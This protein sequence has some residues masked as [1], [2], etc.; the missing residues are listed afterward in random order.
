[1]AASAIQ[2][3]V[4]VHKAISLKKGETLSQFTE[5]LSAAVRGKI[6]EALRIAK[7]KGSA[8][9]M[10][11]TEKAVIV[12]TYVYN[13]SGS[14]YRTYMYKY[15]RD[16]DG[17]F[18]FSDLTEVERVTSYRPKTTTSNVLKS[19]DGAHYVPKQPNDGGDSALLSIN[20][21]KRP[22]RPARVQSPAL[23]RR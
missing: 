14:D 6:M 9:I 11:V 23:R 21:S 1:M 3:D 2:H 15:E 4:I 19:I 17:D 10:E 7:D 8:Y 5:A 12:Q 22:A 20:K 18:E 13:Q 16:T